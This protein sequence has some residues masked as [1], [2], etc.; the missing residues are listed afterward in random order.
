MVD[1]LCAQPLVQF[2]TDQFETLHALL[3]WSV[4]VHMVLALLSVKFLS[5]FSTFKLGHFCCL[6]SSVNAC[7]REDI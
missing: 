2:Y 7:L 6:S 1:T 3:S 4:D 5:L